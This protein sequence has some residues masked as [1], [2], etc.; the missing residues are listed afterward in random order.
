MTVCRCVRLTLMDMAFTIACRW[1]VCESAC[2][3]VV[4]SVA[5][6]PLSVA[7]IDIVVLTVVPATR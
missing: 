5:E 4:A 2:L 1:G 7:N 3:E 6:K